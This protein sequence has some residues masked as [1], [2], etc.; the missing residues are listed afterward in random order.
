MF[1]QQFSN[2]LKGAEEIRFCIRKGDDGRLAVLVEPLLKGSPGG[3]D[4]ATGQ[5]RAALAFPLRIAATAGELDARFLQSL[6][7]YGQAR[8]P[9]ADAFAAAL[10]SAKEALKPAAQAAL[11]AKPAAAKA[12]KDS[13]EAE[14][15][16]D[17]SANP[18]SLF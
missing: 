4:E 12:G 3:E 7:A 13:G 5:L 2:L 8:E 17:W 6:M 15:P 11:Q 10:G 18:E 14:T 9:A 16:A 1:F